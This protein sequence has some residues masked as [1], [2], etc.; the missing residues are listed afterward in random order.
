MI[1]LDRCG[2]WRPSMYEQISA[3]LPSHMISLPETPKTSQL[4]RLTINYDSRTDF[5][6][7]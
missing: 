7:M 3:R 1:G 2:S 5:K 6:V 4:L